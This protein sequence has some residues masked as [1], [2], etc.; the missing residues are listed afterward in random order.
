MVG[1]YPWSSSSCA[2]DRPRTARQPGPVETNMDVL[3]AP[4]MTQSGLL[5][6]LLDDMTA[7]RTTNESTKSQGGLVI[8]GF[9]VLSA[10]YNRTSGQAW[11]GTQIRQVAPSTG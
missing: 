5:C 9:P 10:G 3:P 11:H 2:I 7:A 8:H 6:W 1:V 4:K